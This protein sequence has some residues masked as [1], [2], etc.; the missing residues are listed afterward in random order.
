VIAI[1]DQLPDP[2][3]TF[4]FDQGLESDPERFG[5]GLEPPGRD[6]VFEGSGQGVWDANCNLL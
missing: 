6:E 1:G 2:S 5:P 3:T 4:R